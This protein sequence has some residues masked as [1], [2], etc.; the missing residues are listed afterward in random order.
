MPDP[1]V[2]GN[3]VAENHAR[4]SM[5]LR[6]R[7]GLTALARVKNDGRFSP[8][9]LDKLPPPVI[10]QLAFE[11]RA[12]MFLKLHTL[13][14]D[15]R[16]LPVPP[17]EYASSFNWAR[18]RMTLEALCQC[19]HGNARLLTTMEIVQLSGDNALYIAEFAAQRLR[20]FLRQDHVQNLM[21][22]YALAPPPEEKIDHGLSSMS[23]IYYGLHWLFEGTEDAPLTRRILDRQPI[24]VIGML[25][26]VAQQAIMEARDKLGIRKKRETQDEAAGGVTQSR[27]ARPGD[28]DDY[29]R[30]KI[31]PDRDLPPNTVRLIKDPSHLR[32]MKDVIGL[33]HVVDRLK[34]LLYRIARPDLIDTEPEHALLVG[35]YGVG[36]SLIA[37]AIAREILEKNAQIP[38]P[39]NHVKFAHVNLSN[40]FWKWVGESNANANRL[41]DFL[42]QNAP[43]IVFLDEMEAAMN[44]STN[45]QMHEESLRT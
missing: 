6:D 30:G 33:E 29:S 3:A 42:E 41:M 23:E 9:L 44:D 34:P 5:T 20:D 16:N 10:S 13:Q 39:K 45:V 8:E 22:K 12:A 17:L 43:I 18:H 2:S 15:V 19:E 36:K 35:T 40:V 32:S 28:I 1:A 27:R 21:M 37:E 24:E 25:A 11:A 14:I 26:A 31:D 38:D 4:A 7:L